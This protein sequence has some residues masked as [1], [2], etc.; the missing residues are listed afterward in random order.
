MPTL[1]EVFNP[2]RVDK[3]EVEAPDKA[4]KKWT[5]PLNERQLFNKLLEAGLGHLLETYSPDQLPTLEAI[6]AMG[7]RFGRVLPIGACKR[8]YDHAQRT[9][10]SPIFEEFLIKGEFVSEEDELAN[11]IERERFIK[12]G[13]NDERLPFGVEYV[14]LK[15]PRGGVYAR[16]QSCVREGME[17]FK[18]CRLALTSYL[19]V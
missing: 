8:D 3:F 19:Q 16:L 15:H 2:I 11:L 18:I 14:D 7:G 9:F 10:A 17:E 6:R 12:E 1:S 5:P 4:R 13:V